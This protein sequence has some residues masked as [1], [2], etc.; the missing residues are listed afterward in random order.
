MSKKNKIATML[1]G[2]TFLVLLL[3]TF[4]LPNKIPFHFNASGEAGWF[5]S[6]YLILLFTPVPYL[7]Y[8]QFTS[9]KK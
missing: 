7:L 1:L 4:F 9:K 2:G 5:A 3:A 8:C 6:K